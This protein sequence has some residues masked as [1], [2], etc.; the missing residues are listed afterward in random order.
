MKFHP[1]ASVAASLIAGLASLP[2][3]ADLLASEPFDYDAGTFLQ[4]QDGG[5]GF[6]GRWLG[7]PKFFGEDARITAASLDYPG[8]PAASPVV[9]TSRGNYRDAHRP[10]DTTAGGP[11][12]DLLDDDGNVGK[13]GTELWIAYLARDDSPAT[14]GGHANL[15]LYRDADADEPDEKQAVLNLPLAGVMDDQPHLLVAHVVFGEA[16][17]RVTL[18]VDPDLSGAP[19]DGRTLPAGETEDVSF[20]ML[21]I[22]AE[23]YADPAPAV[24]FDGIQIGTSA[25]DIGFAEALAAGDAEP[26]T[27]RLTVSQTN[28]QQVEGW[29]AFAYAHTSVWGTKTPDGRD[30]TPAEIDNRP[31]ILDAMVNG[32]NISHLRM[33]L[34]ADMYD[35][36]QPDLLG[37]V[38]PRRRRRRRRRCRSWTTCGTWCWRRGS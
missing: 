1:L 12:A 16:G 30:I 31:A 22:S 6:G 29:G 24:T 26:A 23:Y 32:L 5:T 34:H 27:P 8:Y 7:Q 36:D 4:D 15:R 11:F 28:A 37:A 35:A 18:Y 19:K 25:T 33:E 20:D 10:I 3:H 13:A 17:D 2:S 14:T 21:E 38:G 9:V